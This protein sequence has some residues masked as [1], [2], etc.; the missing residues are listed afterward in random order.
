MNKKILGA[1][2]AATVLAAMPLL[3]VFADGTTTV[4]DTLKIT[5]EKS[6]TLGDSVQGAQ[7]EETI[8]PGEKNESLTG[9]AFTIGCNDEGGW[10]LKAKG[11][12][13]T[14]LTSG[15][16]TIAT[17]TTLSGA[18]S[19]WA[20]KAAVTGA[21]AQGSYAEFSAVPSADTTIVKSD[22]ATESASVKITY[23]VYVAHA[24][25]PGTY[26]GGVTYTLTHPAAAD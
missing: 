15:A 9:A 3:G 8:T 7:I 24:Q 4:N 2:A 14:N 6:C 25:K 20:M 10:E 23:G 5:V 11:T 21:T 22:A 12:S 19:A 17:G 18:A 1:S 13:D 16:D 26:Q